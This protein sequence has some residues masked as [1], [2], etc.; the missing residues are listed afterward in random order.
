MLDAR[1][2]PLVDP[3]LNYLGKYLVKANISANTITIVG[4]VLGLAACPAIVYNAY[5]LAIVFILLNR[6]CDGLDGSMAR[7]TQ[8]TDFGGFLDIVCD[9]IFYSAIVFAFTL[10]HPSHIFW[11]SFLIFS[12]IGPI[13]SFLAYAILAAKH[14]RT[15]VKRGQKSFYYLGGICEGTETT[16]ALLS[17]CLFPA[18]FWLIC[19]IYG[20]LCWLTTLGRIYQAWQDF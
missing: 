2:R 4:F 9:F 12:F 19:C 8:L 11:A 5:K 1:I 18:H 6:I 17:M 20:I 15:T 16:L 14:N 10:T 13:S 3:P 7:H